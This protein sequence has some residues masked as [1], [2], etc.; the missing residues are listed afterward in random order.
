MR[1]S[2][3]RADEMEMYINFKL[4]RI[5]YIFIQICLAIYCIYELYISNKLPFVF[6]IWILSGVVFWFS[7]I[8]Y[9]QKLMEDKKNE[10]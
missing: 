9:T 3:F 2:K 10:E 4:V 6:I 7:K 8:Y 1:N 5:A